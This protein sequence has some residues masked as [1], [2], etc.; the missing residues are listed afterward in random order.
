MKVLFLSDLNWQNHLRSISDDEV[1]NFKI[2]HLKKT[3]FQSI[4]KYFSIVEYEAPDLV[5]FAGDITGDGSCG[6]GFHNAFK[7]LL[8]LLEHHSI[9]SKFISG[10]HDPNLYYKQLL[11][12][13]PSLKFCEEISNKKV[14]E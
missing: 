1:Y 13:I 6:H 7:L 10:N 4:A 2:S 9:P 14:T 11:A 12:F 5:L 8:L 3:R